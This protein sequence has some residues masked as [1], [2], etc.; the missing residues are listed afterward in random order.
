MPTS[1]YQRVHSQWKGKHAL[2][3]GFSPR[4]GL[5]AAIFFEAVQVPYSIYEQKGNEDVKKTLANHKTTYLQNIFGGEPQNAFL[6]GIDFILLSPGIARTHPLMAQAHKRNIEIVVD[7]DLLYPFLDNKKTIGVTGTDGKTTTVS[8]L[9]HLLKQYRPVVA[10]GNNGVPILSVIDLIEAAEIIIIELSSYMLEECQHITPGV[11]IITNIA[12]DHLDRYSSFEAYRQT[13][14]KLFNGAK[15]SAI[16]NAD[17]SNISYSGP[18]KQVTIG[19]SGEYSFNE[20]EFV[21]GD[22]KL[23]YKAVPL[24]GLQNRYN[25]LFAIAGCEQLGMPRE[26]IKKGLTTFKGLPHR[27][28]FVVT[29]KGIDVYNDSKAT[30]LQSVQYALLSFKSCVLIMGGG[31]KEQLI[32]S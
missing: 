8:L 26:L 32:E 9:E 1:I 24:K 10:C 29:K 5:S 23:P 16:V 17:D 15:G 25:I 21:L 22:W 7:V 3:V 13:K 30:T 27:L 2:I 31:G 6:Q 4:T 28:E 20:R 14:L 12:P 11:S 18:R 19:T